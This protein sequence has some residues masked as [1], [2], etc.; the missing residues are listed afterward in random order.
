VK[1]LL[2]SLM[3]FAAGCGTKTEPIP[4]AP[5]EPPAPAVAVKDNRPVIVAFGDSLSAGYGADVGS[6]YPDFLQKELDAAGYK[7][8]VANHGVSGDTTSGG[9]ARV[10]QAIELKPY[11]VILELGGNDGLRGL[12]IAVT[13]DNLDKMIL[14]FKDT[15]AKV[16]LAG[17]TLPRNYG[18]DY[19][20]EFEQIYPMLEKKHKVPR[21]RFLLES[22]VLKKG[23]MQ[24]D[25]IHPTAAGN[26]IVAH[27]VFQVI[28]PLLRK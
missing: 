28:A 21:I 3:L 26:K 8:R 16:V 11:L 20:R 19:I 17:M 15:G 27:D 10:P 12:P 25:D 18:P 13:R 1:R 22:V 9:L 4:V 14:A 7:Y 6:S 2:F 23:M 24:Q 5:V